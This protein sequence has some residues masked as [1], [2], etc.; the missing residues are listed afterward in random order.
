MGNKLKNID[1]LRSSEIPKNEVHVRDVF[2]SRT[3]INL[4]VDTDKTNTT[5]KKWKYNA[6][7]IIIENE[8]DESFL[9]VSSKIVTVDSLCVSTTAASDE[10]KTIRNTSSFSTTESGM[11]VMLPHSTRLV[12]LS[13]MNTTGKETLT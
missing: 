12:K 10:L 11:M 4:G 8:T 6:T 7:I 3:K 13:G 1:T 5:Y 9:L 2:P